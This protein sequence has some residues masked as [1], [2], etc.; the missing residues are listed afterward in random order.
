MIGNKTNLSFSAA[1]AILK[2]G[3]RL[4]RDGWN[5]KGMFIYYV[6]PGNYNPCTA[7]A[8]KI[9]NEEGKVPYSAYI[10]FYTVDKKVV[11][12]V[13]SQTDLLA[14]DWRVVGEDD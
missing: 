13:A 9:V 12:W 2:C 8:E 6:R 7:A 1:L 3:Y 10:A 4:Q 5:G 11:P 14:D